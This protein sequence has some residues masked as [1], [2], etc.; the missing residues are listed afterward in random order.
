MSRDITEIIDDYCCNKYG[1]TN[2]A[3]TDTLNEEEQRMMKDR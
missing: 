3:W 2:W 1:H